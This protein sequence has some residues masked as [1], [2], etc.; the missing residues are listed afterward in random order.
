MA[1]RKFSKREV[2]EIQ[3]RVTQL[4]L[5]GHSQAE[6][7]A[8]LGLSQQMVSYYLTKIERARLERCT[9]LESKRALEDARLDQ[10]IV[11]AWEIHDSAQSPAEKLRCLSLILHAGSRRAS[12]LHL[13]RIPPTQPETAEEA[14]SPEDLHRKL[15]ELFAQAGGS[16]LD[17]QTTD[18]AS[19]ARK[20]PTTGKTPIAPRASAAKAK[21]RVRQRTRSDGKAP[22]ADKI[23]TISNRVQP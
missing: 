14:E 20:A 1:V 23:K 6:I 3:D 11:Q 15:V 17:S 8:K 2:A 18:R 12:I 10:V 13:P 9:D 4:H 19:T 7:A 16:A 5:K 22:P 21:P